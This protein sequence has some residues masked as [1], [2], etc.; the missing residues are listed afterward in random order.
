MMPRNFPSHPHVT[1]PSR[2]AGPQGSTGPMAE[3]VDTRQGQE[4]AQ[5]LVRRVQR[6]ARAAFHLLV[7]PY[8]HRLAALIA[9]YIPDWRAC[10]DVSQDNTIPA[11]RP[12]G[13]LL[14]AAQF[15]TTRTEEQR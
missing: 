5:E 8:Q 3:V 7:P 4:L 2:T 14:A 13:T 6:G 15:Q 10:Q 9:R 12:I 1:T 11:H